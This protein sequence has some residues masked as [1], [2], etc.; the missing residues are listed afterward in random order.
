MTDS[1]NIHAPVN[2]SLTSDMLYGLKPAAPTSR[3]FKQNIPSMNKNVFVAGDQAIFEIPSGRKGTYLDPCQTF[4]K[5]SVQTQSTAACAQGGSGVYVDNSAYSFIQRQDI[6]HSSNSLESINEYG[7]LANF[8]L[9]NTL[10]Q[11][12]KAGLS[13]MIGSNPHNTFS[14]EVGA[15]LVNYTYSP[16]SYVP[17]TSPLNSVFQTQVAGDRSGLS[18]ATVGPAIAGVGGINTAVAYTFCLPV[19]S[20]LIG[21]NASKMLPVGKLGN[22]VRIEL[23]LSA[24]DDAIYAGTSALGATWQIVNF[25]LC[26]TYVE[27]DESGFDTVDEP[28]YICSQSYRQTSASLPA[29]TSGEFTTLLPFRFASLTGLYARF[30][31]IITAAQG[32]NATSGY[33]K[34][35]SVNPMLGSYYIRV[36]AQNYPNKPVYLYNGS[37]VN[38]G[39]EGFAELQKS[40]HSLGSITGDPAYKFHEYNVA[41]T[42]IGG[43]NGSF[44]QAS[45]SNGNIDTFAN[46]FCIGMELQTFS[47]RNDT[48]LSGISTQNTQMYFT[49]TFINGQTSCATNMTI[50]F[51]GQYDVIFKIEAGII[52]ATF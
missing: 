33:R 48:I 16:Y 13:S 41:T 8:L 14:A 3:S 18:M 27:I 26:C 36:G 50:D 34:S 1:S 44:V 28:I 25:E 19:L 7:Q 51:F 31:N 37:L 12:Q 29:L 40:F 49:G 10:C 15:P 43:W 47:N 38:T 23:Y 20:S 52:T 4:F 21:V 9:D 24:N 2:K 17:G 6:F 39:S 11:S 46:A 32:A 22:P 35:S 30:R 45:K 42:A 5:F